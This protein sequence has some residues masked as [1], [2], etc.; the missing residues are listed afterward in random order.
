MRDIHDARAKGDAK[1]QLAFD[2]FC[3]GI[4]KYIGAYCAVLGRLDALIFTAGIGENDDLARAAICADLG[5]LGIA[6]DPAKNAQRSARPRAIS[7]DHS[8]VPVLVVPTNEEL[9]IAQETVAVLA[10]NR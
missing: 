9:A 7:P 6:V 2:M 8:P 4:R 1:A 5:I 3:H 10:G